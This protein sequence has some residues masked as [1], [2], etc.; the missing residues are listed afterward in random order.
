MIAMFGALIIIF[1]GL[2]L[3]NNVGAKKRD[4]VQFGKTLK[5][6]SGNLV[7]VT[8][9][10]VSYE[11]FIVGYNI[12]KHSFIVKIDHPSAFSTLSMGDVLVSDQ[13][14]P[15]KYVRATPKLVNSIMTY[16]HPF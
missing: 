13:S 11:V 8:I 9:D 10:D 12:S 4:E 6:F 2:W 1:G 5:N 16:K 14:G 7:T 3:Y 15:Y